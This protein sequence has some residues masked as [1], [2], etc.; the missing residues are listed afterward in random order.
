MNTPTK[1]FRCLLKIAAL[2]LLIIP[3]CNKPAAPPPKEMSEALDAYHCGDDAAVIDLTG[4]V[5]A[6]KPD[7]P[8]A[9]EAYYLRELIEYRQSKLNE[10]V[11]DLN[12]AMARSQRTDMAAT[13]NCIIAMVA[14]QA[15]Q[16]DTARQKYLKAIEIFDDLGKTSESHENALFRLG[17]LLQRQGDFLEADRYFDR[18]LHSYS[19]GRCAAEARQH[20]RGRNWTLFIASYPTMDHARRKAD[21]L[22][23]AGLE[24][25]IVPVGGENT[26]FQVH[27]GR[28]DQ[29]RQAAEA[30]ESLAKKLPQAEIIVER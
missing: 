15:G 4:R 29:Y 25:R 8:A 17:L 23:A 11:E 9:G 18:L 13:A 24:P 2:L 3:A 20:I 1:P 19:E 7:S 26:Q 16:E 30:A 5:I 27:V 10:A 28:Y 12:K 6:A 22:T 21:E 14:E